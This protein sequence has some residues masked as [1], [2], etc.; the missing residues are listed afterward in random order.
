M[1]HYSSSLSVIAGIQ[2]GPLVPLRLFV[3]NSPIFKEL[4]TEEPEEYEYSFRRHKANEWWYQ[5]HSAITS[6]QYYQDLHDTIS[7]R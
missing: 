5:R 2:H 4:Q 1:T 3:I 6:Y 7:S